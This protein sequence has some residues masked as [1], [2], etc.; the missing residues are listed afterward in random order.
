MNYRG[1]MIK[2]SEEYDGYEGE[3]YTMGAKRITSYS[4]DSRSDVLF[5]C[6]KYINREKRDDGSSYDDYDGLPTSWSY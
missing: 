3:V 1:Y 4:G 5:E 6:K 2:I